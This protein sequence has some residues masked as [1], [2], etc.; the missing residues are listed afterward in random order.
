MLRRLGIRGKVLAAL[1]VPVLVIL[2]LAGQVSLQAIEGA[3][4]ARAVT[5]L[6]RVLQESRQV[7]ET[8]QAER[9]AAV[10]YVNPDVVAKDL[11]TV[12]QT[13]ED[14][15]EAIARF[16]GAV[17]AVDF[18][19]L[20]PAVAAAVSD[21]RNAFATLD[22]VHG[23]V[24]SNVPL[25]S[26]V[27]NYT[28]A[29]EDTVAF[30]EAVADA[31]DDRRLA[32]IISANADLT[33]L[34]ED[35]REEQVRGGEVLSGARENLDVLNLSNLFPASKIAHQ[36]TSSTV[37]ALELGD[38]VVVPPL[39]ASFDGF[40][41]YDSY[42]TL[43]S[44]GEKQN[45]DFI[46]PDDWRAAADR[47]IVAFEPLASE[48]RQAATQRADA[49]AANAVR[50]AVITTLVALGAL[51]ASVVIA[52]SI[53]RQIVVPLRRLTEAAGNVRDE[54]PRLVDQVAVP[55]QGP[56][57]T[58][59]QIPVTSRDEIGQLA[60]AFNEVNAT[61][62]QVAQEQ[63]A[64][65]GSI[66]EMFVNVARR[67]QVLLNRQLSFIDALERS[68]EDPKTLADL[69]RLDHLAT[70]MRRNAESL[71]V[72]AGID[73]GRR[74][75]DALPLSDVIRTASSEIEHYERVLLDLPV[76]PMMLGH[77]ALPAAHML[78]ELLENATVFSEPGTPVQV[79]TG[80]DERSVIITVLDQGLGMT[81]EE[82]A[83]AN[84][85]IRTTSAGDVLGSQRLG[86]FVVGRIAARLGTTAELA[87]GPDGKGT[88]ATIR[89]PLVLF[90]DPGSIPLTP[91]TRPAAAQPE[92][93][94]LPE[95]AAEV[96]HDTAYAPAP[97]HVQDVAP[98]AYGSA[99][100]PAE[101]V[102]LQ[103]LTDGTTGLG[104]PRRRSRGGDEEAPAARV[105][106]R[107][108]D[109]AAAA[110]SIP[111][112]PRADA[113]AGAAAAVDE[114]WAPP[115]VVPSAPLVSRRGADDGAALPSRAPA[116]GGLP[117]RQPAAAAP[118]AP[119]GLPTRSPA[120]GGLPTRQPA[121]PAGPEPRAVTG[122]VPPVAPEGRAAM[123]SGFRSRRAEL[124]A[125]AV[126]VDS[127]ETTSE[128]T[129]DA[130][131]GVDGADRLAAA[132]AGGQG[133]AAFFSRPETPPADK[134]MVIPALVE[135]DEDELPAAVA[136]TV[137]EEQAVWSAPEAQAQ[138]WEAPAEAQPQ[139]WEQPEQ[140]WAAQQAQPQPWAAQAEPQ[141][142]AAQAEPQPQP[143]EQP[144][145]QWEQPAQP[146]AAQ[147]AEPQPWAPAEP[148]APQPWAPA[149]VEPAAQ[150]QPWAP[151]P[152]PVDAQPW[153]PA[154]VEAAAQA[155]P[156]A[157]AP[158]D[159]QPWAPAPVDAQPWGPAEPQAQAQPWA[160]TPAPVQ[161]EPQP[162]AWSQP[163]APVAPAAP[164]APV[165]PAAPAVETPAFTELV[166]GPSRRDIRGKKP[167]RR[168]FGRRQAEAAVV[169]TP[170][171]PAPVEQL[172]APAPY[173]A[174]EPV[175]PPVRQS[176][177]GSPDA[178]A[179][180]AA[181]AQPAAPAP[182][183]APAAPQ[184]PAHAPRSLSSAFQPRRPVDPAQAAPAAQAPSAPVAPA[185]PA[186]TPWNPPPADT[187]QGWQGAAAAAVAEGS[188]GWAP[189]AAWEPAAPQAP[190]APAA[191][192][193][194][195]PAQ[196]WAPTAPADASAM[197]ARPTASVPSPHQPAQTTFTPQTFSPQTS[198]TPQSGGAFDDE[199]TNMLAQRADIAQQALAELSQLSSY[200][201][202]AA[203]GGGS[204]LARRTPGT[205]P[206]AP[207]IKIAPAG[208]RVE[209]DANQV[210][211][212][213]SSFQSGTSRGRQAAPAPA[214][215]ADHQTPDGATP[216]G[217]DG[218]D[219][220][221]IPVT[222]PDT[223]LT[224]RTTSW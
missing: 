22:G 75:R 91:P 207:E 93:F 135:D 144:A 205:I 196:G 120:A 81:P 128:A 123:F 170:A 185:A 216:V 31:L 194:W 19:A 112:A 201:P 27:N 211:S 100:N 6:L 105:S 221:G 175:V 63:A 209:R 168:L 113:L 99:E 187:A 9:A 167:R 69:F 217:K 224:E 68:E 24:D 137:A 166:Q 180:A 82:L 189:T 164:A 116:A 162:Q 186:P 127:G 72:L 124:A 163:V 45:F 171:A 161:P 47:E 38:G 155:E 71:L 139:A 51:A 88:L 102:D 222:T 98:G 42:R 25:G 107:E 118:A 76:D 14:T 173:V 157:P 223:D 146:W 15:A 115:V 215:P 150:A 59:T 1:S 177:W 210:R 46:A 49:V 202:A 148:V 20:D 16:E 131:D 11:V 190:A 153:A 92:A 182:V 147:A 181:Q 33:S 145:Q 53:A 140:P 41:S 178:G 184:L 77:T 64:L 188:S 108:A 218:P 78:A 94:V 179:H 97:A 158:V 60:T 103:A 191:A 44:S 141:P 40:Q 198:F 83:E 134:P 197:P 10:P 23:R 172:P 165:V 130:L 154:P 220:H 48:L 29:I 74:L 39:G 132:A 203:S 18:D 101:E 62:I 199:V 67:D 80:I 152:A 169:P 36:Q 86:M 193:A 206:T 66:A 213:L 79:S 138:P 61:T 106:H 160:P 133:A 84:E 149:P 32:A 28:R 136:E 159:P 195:A 117:T 7:V 156:W 55:G 142:W 89:M 126:H 176:A 12:M 73:T 85:K 3:Q 58:L 212:L 54:L 204:T 96:V 104:L 52:L 122:P 37:R 56:D 114:A 129:P 219:A 4:T 35:Y 8:L 21:V 26:I 17:E 90:V 192:P 87:L 121:A 125:A 110:P 111:L 65:R 143:W 109:D 208:Q 151:A 174:P 13:R 34:V 5:S 2:A 43:I 95:Q 57:L 183:E 200:R 70:R 30:P 119:S 50:E 214:G